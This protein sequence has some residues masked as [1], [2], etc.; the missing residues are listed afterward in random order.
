[1]MRPL[2]GV[3]RARG[4]AVASK[5]AAPLSTVTETGAASAQASQPPRRAAAGAQ[6]HVSRSG[7]SASR[8]RR[9]SG[10]VGS[11]GTWGQRDWMPRAT[12]P[13]GGRGGEA[14]AATGRNRS[15]QQ[16]AHGNP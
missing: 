3:R 14:R 7:R 2:S 15:M 13:G 12:A 6:A 4:G 9:V 8:A 1:V 11:M 16:Y 10:K 5:R